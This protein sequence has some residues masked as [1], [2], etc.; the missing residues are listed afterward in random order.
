[1]LFSPILKQLSDSP[2]KTLQWEPLRNSDWISLTQE[3]LAIDTTYTG[4]KDTGYFAE[5]S[6]HISPSVPVESADWWKYSCMKLYEEPRCH[7]AYFP[8]YVARSHFIP[9]ALVLQCHADLSTVA[10]TSAQSPATR[11][12]PGCPVSGRSYF[13]ADRLKCCPVQFMHVAKEK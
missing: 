9:R 7:P 4:R 13:E 1:M 11:S 12:H 10:H 3:D 8:A 5:K 6:L 2:S